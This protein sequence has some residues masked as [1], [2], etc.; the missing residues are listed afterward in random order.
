MGGAV[1]VILV[2]D[3]GY[4]G[5]VPMEVF[6][7]VVAWGEVAGFKPETEPNFF[8]FW[9]VV[10]GNVDVYRRVLGISSY[11]VVIGGLTLEGFLGI[12]PQDYYQSY[13]YDIFHFFL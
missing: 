5:P 7:V 4:A 2:A 10:F 12:Y 1:V 6:K 3:S 13:K 9:T 11:T 8:Y